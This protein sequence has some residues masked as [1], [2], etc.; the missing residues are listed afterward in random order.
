VLQ[1]QVIAK[2]PDSVTCSHVALSGGLIALSGGYIWL[3][4]PES[5]TIFGRHHLK[6][7]QY[8]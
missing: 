3:T 8:F 5:A 2:P 7:Q 1:F 4:P 6:V